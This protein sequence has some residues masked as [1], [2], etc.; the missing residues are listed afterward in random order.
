MVARTY[1]S[2]TQLKGKQNNVVQDMLFKDFGVNWNDFPVECKRGTSCIKD[3][4]GKWF[5]DYNMPILKGEDRKYVDKWIY[6]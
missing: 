3:E 5:I 2:D 1:Y 6:V 4:K